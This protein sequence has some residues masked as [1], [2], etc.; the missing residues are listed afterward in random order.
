MGQELA[1]I[2]ARHRQGLY[3]LALSVTRCPAAAEDAVHEA[4]ARLCGRMAG[5]GASDLVAYVFSAVRNAAVDQLRRVARNGGDST[6]FNGRS[7]S[8]DDQAL[9]DEQE[10][11]VIEALETLDPDQREVIVLKVYA[12]L[13]FAQIAQVVAAPLQT[14]ATRYRRGLER[15]RTPLRRLL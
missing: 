5:S 15:L 8:A 9:T 7:P 1:D 4:F 3:T 13:T 12:D 2:Y 11:L 6:I 10:R 14:V